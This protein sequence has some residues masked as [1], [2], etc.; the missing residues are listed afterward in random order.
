MALVRSLRSPSVSTVSVR[1]KVDRERCCVKKFFGRLWRQTLT[2]QSKQAMIVSSVC[3][4]TLN[5]S[6]G[7]RPQP[8]TSTFRSGM[9]S[10][11]PIGHVLPINPYQSW[12]WTSTIIKNKKIKTKH[13]FEN[14]EKNI[15]NNSS[16]Y[17]NKQCEIITE[18]LF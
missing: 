11:Q 16:D 10:D 5:W 13:T 14:P 7:A 12:T 17:N 3:E 4:Q 8:P 18:R 2:N 1:M 6:L 9:N 15:P